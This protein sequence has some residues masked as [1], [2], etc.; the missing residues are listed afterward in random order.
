VTG[1][2]TGWSTASIPS[3]SDRVA[4]VTGASSGLGLEV[5]AE[6]AAHGAHVVMA[7]RSPDK[8]DAALAEVRRRHRAASVEAAQVDLASLGSI[9]AGAGALLTTHPRIDLL[10]DNAG[11]MAVPCSETADGFELQFGT[12]HLG[13]FALTGLLLGALAE[14]PGSRVVV[15]T[16]FMRRRGD[17]DF[18]DLHGRRRY[19]KWKA[20]SQS[21]LANLVFAV[22]LD[23]RLRESGAETIAVAAH[24]GYAATNLQSGSNPIQNI[25]LRIGNLLFAQPAAGGA[26]PLLY[27]ATAP[28]VEGG[29]LYGPAG[30]MRGAPRQEPL[31]PKELD[32]GVARRLWD[33]SVDETGVDYALLG[34]LPGS[35][36]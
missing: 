22:E 18:D 4:V 29:E 13:H 7:A 17:I 23:R 35:Q 5:S 28:G 36:G 24:P 9:R 11:V 27:A 26:L 32:P 20:Y 31:A 30:G 8:L 21:K 3:Q 16:S 6:L 33:A 25:A 34:G 10:I 12:N 15:V 2:S 19:G 1:A 14:T